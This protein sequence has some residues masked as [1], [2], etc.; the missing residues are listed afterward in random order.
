MNGPSVRIPCEAVPVLPPDFDDLDP[1]YTSR[2]LEGYELDEFVRGAG[3]DWQDFTGATPVMTATPPPSRVPL[4]PL[5]PLPS[6]PRPPSH[7]N[8][9]EEDFIPILPHSPPLGIPSR[10]RCRE[11]EEAETGR[12]RRAAPRARSPPCCPS[13]PPGCRPWSPSPHR[14]GAP[15]GLTIRIPMGNRPW[16]RCPPALRLIPDTRTVLSTFAHEAH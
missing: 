10:N 4:P 14:C 1:E 7:P 13:L 9:D 2:V 6:R 11:S 3:L 8:W 16:Y 15:R 12:E 5:P